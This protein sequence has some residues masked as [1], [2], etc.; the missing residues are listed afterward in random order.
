MQNLLRIGDFSRLAQVSVPTLRHYDE[1]GLLKPAE[2]DR[3]TD[4][5]YYALEQLPRLNRILALKDLGLSL[6]QIKTLLQQEMPAD[7]LRHMLADKRADIEKQLREE[8]ARL[9]RVEARLRQ[10]EHEGEP[11]PQFD[12]VM[13]ATEAQHVAV[14]R[15][16]VPHLLQMPQL[17]AMA[18][19]NVYDFLA[20]HNVNSL[21]PELFQYFN[22]GWTEDDIDMGAGVA[23]DAKQGRSLQSTG[24]R[25]DSAVHVL[26]LPAALC[27]ASITHHGKVWDLPIVI[28]GI[29]AWIGNNGYHSVGP[30]RELHL[31]W[32]E[33]QIEEDNELVF[34]IQLPVEPNAA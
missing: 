23:L 22:E 17:R 34:E 5:R 16:I 24:S 4:Y 6:E 11:Q 25:A 31:N 20:Q 1:L 3:F 30:I 32:R 8:Q 18:L 19:N 10:I 14:C 26:Q 27:V 15:S 2:V 7:R 28:S 9:A 21:G 29:H 33:C 13:K 12:V